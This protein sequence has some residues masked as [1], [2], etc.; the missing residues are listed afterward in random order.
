VGIAEHYDA[1]TKVKHGGF[2]KVKT[3]NRIANND[4]DV[5]ASAR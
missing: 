5:S 4:D 2:A 3:E 1:A